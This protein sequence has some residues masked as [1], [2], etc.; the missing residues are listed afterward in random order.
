[1]HTEYCDALA[2]QSEILGKWVSKPFEHMSFDNTIKEALK[3]YSQIR[4]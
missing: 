2:T 1:M 3:Y 4:H